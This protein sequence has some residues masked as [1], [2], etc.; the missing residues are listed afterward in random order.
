MSLHRGEKGISSIFQCILRNQ[1]RSWKYHDSLKIGASLRTNSRF[2]GY[3]LPS[4]TLLYS[5]TSST[6]FSGFDYSN[7]DNINYLNPISTEAGSGSNV[8]FTKTAKR[9]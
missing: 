1:I 6:T 7:L 8:A 9:K 2:Y 3:H 4:A 5:S